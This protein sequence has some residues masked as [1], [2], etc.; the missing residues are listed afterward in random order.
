V[1]VVTGFEVEVAGLVVL[2]DGVVVAG[3]ERLISLEI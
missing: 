3:P 2:V 1:A